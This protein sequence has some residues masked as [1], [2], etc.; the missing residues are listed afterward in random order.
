MEELLALT[1]VWLDERRYFHARSKIYAEK[2][3]KGDTLPQ[4]RGAI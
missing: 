2:P 4:L 3:Y 1:F